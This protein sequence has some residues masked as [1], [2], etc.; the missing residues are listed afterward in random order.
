ML[1]QH[2]PSMS[3][4]SEAEGTGPVQELNLAIEGSSGTLSISEMPE[5]QEFAPKKSQSWGWLLISLM[6][7]MAA[8]G[9][10][11][12]AFVWLINLPPTVD[13]KNPTSIT[14]DR[15]QLYCAQVAAETGDLDAILAS[16]KLVGSWDESHPLHYE[17]QPLVEQWSWV[18]LKEAQQK[19]SDSDLEG[20]V[21][22]ID[23]IPGSSPVYET[24]QD[25]LKA[26]N[27]EWDQ[28]D[29]IWQQA[30][31]ALANQDWGEASR[32]VL[33][34][35][36]LDNRHWR[37]DQVQA[38]SQ[39]IRQER[40]ARQRLARAV[41]IASG[42]GVPQLGAAL[43]ITSQIN[44]STYAYRDAQPYM[45]RWSDE[46]LKLGLDKWYAAELDEAISLS[47][48]AAV[49]PNRAKAA[50]ELIWLSK[51]RQIARDS[52]GTWRTSPDQLVKLYRAMVVAN[53]IPSDSPYYPQAQSSVDTW[54]IHL[55]DLSKLQMAQLPGRLQNLDAL[56]LAI[57]QAAQVP[58][59]HPRRQQA[60]TL[61]AHWRLEV[62]RLE[63]RP[64]LARAHQLAKADTIEG[65]QQAI[66]TASQIA[67]N[68]ALRNEAQSW[69][70][71]WENQI[72]VLQDRPTLTAARD[73][74]DAGNYSQA[75]AE[76]SNI[77]T[78]RALFEEAQ[79]AITGWRREIAAIEQARQR[80]QRRAAER[81][82]QV[83]VDRPPLFPTPAPVGSESPSVPA[84]TSPPAARPTAPAPVR[85]AQ[86]RPPLPRQIETVPGDNAPA[87]PISPEPDL[88]ATS[89]P[90]AR[91]RPASVDSPALVPASPMESP[92][93]APESAPVPL[94][95]AA[96]ISPPAPDL[97]I[98][99]APAPQPQ[100]PVVPQS[101]TPPRSD[102]IDSPPVSSPPA[103]TSPEPPSV[104]ATP[105]PEESISLKTTKDASVLMTGALYVAR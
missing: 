8:S 73:L 32:Q 23:H 72:E 103:V 79:A 69:I 74:A 89:E 77:K 76:A 18:V 29:E 22:L 60:Q 97:R 37:V 19:L 67:L 13:C 83:D 44:D 43:R 100:L 64:Y 71:V 14:S 1:N 25:S 54:R 6:G 105:A 84:V 52:I 93:V 55:G 34:L 68:R 66:E 65:L 45:D 3:Q 36:E 78:G 51:S 26:W 75:I 82:R 28:G 88:P 101:V 95:P 80:A 92:A 33:A 102:A 40:Q 35:S 104:S 27:N 50:Q 87:R 47:R 70:Y 9:A 53:Q 5:I 41:E 98:P 57:H 46:L 49:N 20:A 56:K 94:E 24:A 61:I 16:L 99:A 96:P 21:A 59:D 7:C 48:N 10:A 30:Q 39:Q 4:P 11:I 62:E 42:G 90:P 12:G 58:I 38:L 86:V 17:V 85:P 2:S 63:D 91:P 15:A 31:T 81:R